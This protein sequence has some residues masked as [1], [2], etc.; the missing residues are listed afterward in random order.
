MNFIDQN[1]WR[2][3]K[4]LVTGH[5]GFKGGWLSIWLQQLGA[6]VCG[7]GLPPYTSP[8]LFELAGLAD[9]MESYLIDIRDISTLQRQI[10][11]FSPDV[12]FHLAAQPLVRQAYVEPQQ[13]FAT[14][15]LGSVNLLE[16]IRHCPSV[17]AVVMV[18]TDKV[19]KNRET[20]QP[21]TESDRLGG[22]D[23][24]SASKAACEIVI[25]SFRDS[26]FNELGIR[27]ASAR[28]GNV[29]GG[30]DWS[31]DRLLPDVIRSWQQQKPLYIRRPASVR[32]WQHVLEP[33]SGYLR[34]AQLLCQSS[35]VID[36]A[37]NFG[38]EPGD[39][40]SV[41]SVLQLVQSQLPDLQISYG[42]GDGGPHEAGLLLLDIHKSA[43][44]LGWR[45][46]WSISEAIKH[47][48]DWYRAVEH[49]QNA[50]DLCVQDIKK[51]G[52]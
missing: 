44:Q 10:Q 26:F 37:Y 12:V 51:Y 47:T 4:V 20:E 2:Q 8:S 45:P 49:K 15:V 35:E 40:F 5:T 22:Y 52:N 3:K 36:G 14:N 27:I 46:Q 24:Y 43:T 21:Y 9:S 34:L 48:I 11:A 25:D 28:A 17:K 6:E 7:I 16:S 23:P 19:Y 33:L 13:T 31:G 1:F 42:V 32:P 38:P 41:K 50:L 18:T 30:G 29:I 39:N